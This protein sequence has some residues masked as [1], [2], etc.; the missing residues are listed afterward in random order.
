MKK[1][2]KHIYIIMKKDHNINYKTGKF[3]GGYTTGWVPRKIDDE[4][5]PSSPH[6]KTTLF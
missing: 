1:T 3:G 5:F 6:T 2:R 4:N